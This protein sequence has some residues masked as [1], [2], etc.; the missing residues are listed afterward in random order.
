MRTN[1]GREL[2]PERDRKMCELEGEI[3]S[4][5]AFWGFIAILTLVISL[6]L[7]LVAMLVIK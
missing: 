6:F 3:G 1:F 4:L 7:I 2:D 5:L